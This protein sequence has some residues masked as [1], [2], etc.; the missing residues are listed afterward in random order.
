V[1]TTHPPRSVTGGGSI[2]TLGTGWAASGTADFNRDGLGDI[3]LQNG[4]QLAEWQ[5]NGT[6][7]IGG[8]T[9]G[10]LERAGL[11][12]GLATSTEMATPIC[13][14]RTASN[15]PSGK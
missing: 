4:Q 10:T 6:S 13:Y 7:V 8:G 3:L 11:W 14:F 1:V 12:R 9:I 5:M 2:G 15:L